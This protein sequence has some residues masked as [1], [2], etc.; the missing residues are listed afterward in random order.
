MM[1]P[2]MLLLIPQ[3]M[4]ARDLGLLNSLW[5]LIVVYSVM[6]LGLN[7]FLLRGFYSAMPQ[8]LF[9]SASVDGAG[10]W[11]AFRLSGKPGSHLAR[12]G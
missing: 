4:L 11:R 1:V 5:G 8:A 2:G 3:F 6:N 10:P 9:D 12:V 7:T